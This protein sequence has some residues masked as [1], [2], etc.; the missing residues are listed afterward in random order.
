[1]KASQVERSPNYICAGLL[2]KSVVD[3]DDMGAV[4]WY[5]PGRYSAFFLEL[6]NSY[7][8]LPKRYL[9]P[10]ARAT[11]RNNPQLRKNKHEKWSHVRERSEEV[12]K[13]FRCWPV[14]ALE[15]FQW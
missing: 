1:M 13:V 10:S 12:S 11:C 8:S 14:I 2:S 9:C 3:E 5:Q 6:H 15:T 4:L 7:L